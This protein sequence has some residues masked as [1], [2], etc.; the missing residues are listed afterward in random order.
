[1]TKENIFKTFLEDPIFLEKKHLTK[2]QINKI[3][4]I[5]TTNDKLIE[6]IKIAVSG[7]VDGET[8]GN[9]SRRINQ[10]LNK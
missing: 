3:K 8:E 10:F 1:M 5:E 9:I 4:F 7:N 6:V 2:E